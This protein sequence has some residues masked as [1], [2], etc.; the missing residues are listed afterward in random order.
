MEE[1]EFPIDA[2]FTPTSASHE[3]YA[4]AQLEG[5]EHTGILRPNLEVGRSTRP[6]IGGVIAKLKGFV[7]RA[8]A[9]SAISLAEQQTRFNASMLAYVAELG[10]EVV[11]LRGALEDRSTEPNAGKPLSRGGQ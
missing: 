2:L 9:P 6:V 7:V 4:R 8:N 1:G 3:V 5:A 10:A 11:R